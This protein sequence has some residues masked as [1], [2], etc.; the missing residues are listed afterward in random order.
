MDVKIFVLLIVTTT[1]DKA[2]TPRIGM[3]VMLVDVKLTIRM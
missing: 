3:T 2:K 1:T